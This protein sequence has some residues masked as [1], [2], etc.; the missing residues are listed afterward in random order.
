M[1]RIALEQAK[2][3]Q[4]LAR[5]LYYHYG[6][7]MLAAGTPLTRPHIDKLREFGYLT[8]YIYDEDTEDIAALDLID[9]ATRARVGGKVR[10][11]FED[12]RKDT[13]SLFSAEDLVKSSQ[14]DIR[15]KLSTGAIAKSV[16]RDF[17]PSAFIEDVD[18]I[19]E[20]LLAERDVCLSVGTLK[21]MQTFLYDHSLEVTLKAL[22]VGRH[23]GMSKAQL[24]TLGLGSLLHDIGYL[25][26]PE[27]LVHRSGQASLTPQEKATLQRHTMLGY[28]LLREQKALSVAT[29]HVAYQHHERQDGQGY[30]RGLSGTNRIPSGRAALRDAPGVIHR[31]AAI[32][33]VANVHD[34]LVSARPGHTPLPEDEAVLVLRKAAGTDLNQEAVDAYLSFIPVFPVG[35]PVVVRDGRFKG[36]RGV[37]VKVF[38]SDLEQPLVRMIYKGGAKL[39]KPFTVDLREELWPIRAVPIGE[40]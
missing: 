38:P 8:L 7:V 19:L 27:D 18:K 12:L 23:F 16:A 30:P 22:L 32:V 9:D 25:F 29:A 5:T 14:D 37:V 36:Y 34:N 35:T 13:V 6:T 2:P 3:G 11:L 26:L 1:L 28:C 21:S 17:I 39:P 33:A 10:R 20:N 31:F 24:R 4:K 15:R 40:E